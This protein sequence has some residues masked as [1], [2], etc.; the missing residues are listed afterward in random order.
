MQLADRINVWSRTH[1]WDT[2]HKIIKHSM[3]PFLLRKSL[4]FHVS[5]SKWLQERMGKLPERERLGKEPNHLELSPPVS[6]F[7]WALGRTCNPV[8]QISTSLT[9]CRD[10]QRRGSLWKSS[11]A[12]V[13]CFPLIEDSESSHLVT[14]REWGCLHLPPW[15]T[16]SHERVMIECSTLVICRFESSQRRNPHKDMELQSP[17]GSSAGNGAWD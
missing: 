17:L 5:H 13:K 16:S 4:S 8:E 3:H 1:Y 9:W 10:Q 14:R 11:V 12:L 7:R 2:G 6:S 15:S